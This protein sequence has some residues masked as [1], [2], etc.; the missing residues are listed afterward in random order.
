MWRHD[1]YCQLHPGSTDTE[2]EGGTWMK[3]MLKWNL[4]AETIQ[5]MVKDDIH[6][7]SCLVLWK[8]SYLLSHVCR[9]ALGNGWTEPK[10][11]QKCPTLPSW[12]TSSDP[13]R[14]LLLWRNSRGACSSRPPG[15]T[16]AQLP[17]QESI[18]QGEGEYTYYGLVATATFE[19]ISKS[20][21]VPSVEPRHLI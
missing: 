8:M 7:D 19:F 10:R 20:T 14:Q 12:S 1:L 5:L 9:A 13:P 15:A 11:Q 6:N 17:Q 3:S 2:D 4:H 21:S 18:R 16:A